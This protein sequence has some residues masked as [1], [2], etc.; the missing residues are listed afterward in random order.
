MDPFLLMLIVLLLLFLAMNWFGKKKQAQLQSQRLA[1]IQVGN[2]VRTHSGFYG[3]IVDVDGDA[4]TLETPSGVE[5][6]WHK[7]A[8]AGPGEPPFAV[9]G[10]EEV[11]GATS[12][13]PGRPGARG[14]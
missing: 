10:D 7:N 2:M 13:D 12:E 6:V 4:V 3:R 9:A 8:I 11:P 5:T 14:E 1:A